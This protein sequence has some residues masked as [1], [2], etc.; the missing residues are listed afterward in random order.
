MLFRHLLA[1]MILAGKKTQ[2][3]RLCKDGENWQI[4]PPIPATVLDKN[5][6]IKWQE[7]R[8]YA[9]Q[10]K[11]G[12]KAIG[13]FRVT[14]IRREIVAQ[15]SNED[16]KAEGFAGRNE[17]FVTWDSINGA[18]TSNQYCWVIEFEIVN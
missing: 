15:I 11:R 14:N 6:R 13:R 16:A 5:G 1:E 4:F 7:G 9:I 8:D 18:D 12:G 3:R 2:T 17:F 10:T